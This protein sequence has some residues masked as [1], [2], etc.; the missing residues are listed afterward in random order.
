MLWGF[1][2]WLTFFGL[3]CDAQVWIINF[4]YLFFLGVLWGSFFILFYFLFIFLRVR[5]ELTGICRNYLGAGIFLLMAMAMGASRP[6]S[7]DIRYPAICMHMLYGC[8]CYRV[9]RVAFTWPAIHG[10]A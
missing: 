1:F 4:F 6:C 3:H 7:V 2:C 8:V 9:P 10:L 5:I